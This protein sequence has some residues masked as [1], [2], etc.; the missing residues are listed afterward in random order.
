VNNSVANNTLARHEQPLSVTVA[1]A[2]DSLLATVVRVRF[3]IFQ[4]LFRPTCDY[5]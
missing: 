3:L 2:L 4:F 5:L 1:A